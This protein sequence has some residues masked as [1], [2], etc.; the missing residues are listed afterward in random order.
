MEG[1]E[2]LPWGVWEC[3]GEYCSLFLVE[4]VMQTAYG[5]VYLMIFIALKKKKDALRG[6]GEDE[7]SVDKGSTCFTNI[8]T[9][10]W[11]PRNHAKS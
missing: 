6:W 7:V 5:C 10:V 11:I 9:G 4:T 8:R 1:A 2:C 3:L